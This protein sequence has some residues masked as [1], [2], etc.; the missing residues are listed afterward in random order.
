M[1]T[2][3]VIHGVQ[4]SLRQSIFDIGGSS[5]VPG[6]W[7]SMPTAAGSATLGTPA[8]TAGY[9]TEYVKLKYSPDA[10][11]A[12]PPSLT[13]TLYGY[14][15]TDI[16]AIHYLLISTTT[17]MATTP[18]YTANSSLLP[19][20]A[21]ITVAPNSAVLIQVL[22]T[23]ETINFSVYASNSNFNGSLD[24]FSVRVRMIPI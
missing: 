18:T 3:V 21:P 23:M 9:Q 17:N 6:G 5:P 22:D 24:H 10:S 19:V 16:F 1:G 15:E 8:R 13:F 12:S 2:E 14:D 4:N 20:N 11:T 7:T